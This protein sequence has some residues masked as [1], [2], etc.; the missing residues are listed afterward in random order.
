MLLKVL[1]T[2]RRLRIPLLRAGG[3]QTLL[4]GFFNLLLNHQECSVKKKNKKG[5]RP[6]QQEL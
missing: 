6:S 2:A 4:C 5:K 3:C 1:L